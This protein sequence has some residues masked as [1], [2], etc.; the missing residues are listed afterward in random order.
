MSFIGYEVTRDILWHVTYY[1]W[2]DFPQ[3]LWISD[4][5]FKN[6]YKSIRFG[7]VAALSLH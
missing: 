4:E 6:I 7:R 5:Y 1:G 2:P 3:G